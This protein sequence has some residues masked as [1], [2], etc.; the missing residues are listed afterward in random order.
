MNARNKSRFTTTQAAW[1]ALAIFS[2]W[3][4]FLLLPIGPKAERPVARVPALLDGEEELRAAGLRYNADWVGLPTYFKAWASQLQRSEG[5]IIF[6]YWDPGLRTYS[7]EFEAVRTEHGYR[8]RFVHQWPPSNEK[9]E[10][11]DANDML[12]TH[13]FDFEFAVAPVAGA[14]DL[15][16]PPALFEPKS[17]S[18]PDGKPAV[19]IDL[20]ASPL[21]VPEPELKN[22]ADGKK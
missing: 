17:L 8:F 4:G 22:T 12:P 6:R 10:G 16:S 3:V 5:K 9:R 15:P 19:T 1:I 13:P 18:Q 7:Y 11:L 14:I 2:G 20:K 21:T